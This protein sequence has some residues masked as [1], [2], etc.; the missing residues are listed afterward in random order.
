LD[1]KVSANSL[2]YKGGTVGGYATYL[3]QNFFIDA[4]FKA[5]L[6]KL[7]WNAA[8]LGGFGA[9]SPET[10]ANSYGVTVDTGYRFNSV[11]YF[12]EPLATFSWV[13]TKIDAL[14]VL[15]TDIIFGSSDSVRGSL[16]GRV[17]F[18]SMWNAT[19]VEAS[20]T[21]RVWHEFEDPAPLAVLSGALA[22]QDQFNGTYGD[23]NGTLNFIGIN[24]G[25][26]S[27]V[28]GGVKW[29]SDLITVSAKGG[30]RY[31]W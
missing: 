24:S 26:S 5:D 19:K 14:N 6:L 16:G 4:V 1:Y 22:L 18:A 15:G 27:F 25:W 21:G 29:N 7:T 12:F 10:D 31:Q 20:I 2:D 3:N 13:R 11:R 17:G 28:S 8:T 23:V 30:V 9:G